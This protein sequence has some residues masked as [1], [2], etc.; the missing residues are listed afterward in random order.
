LDVR[1]CIAFA[2]LA[3]LGAACG[4]PTSPAKQAEEIGSVAAEGQLLAD[5]AAGD[6]TF[7]SFTRVHARALEE[8]LG[9]LEPKVA[10]AELE[11][12]LEQVVR[13]LAELADESGDADRAARIEDELRAAADEARGVAQ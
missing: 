2:A 4:E 1:R 7:D 13:S 11:T 10:D 3:L 12:L 6:D 5:A 8:R 9:R